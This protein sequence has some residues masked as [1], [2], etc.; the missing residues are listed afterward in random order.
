MDKKSNTQDAPL[1]II[2]DE[3]DDIQVVNEGSAAKSGSGVQSSYKIQNIPAYAFQHHL[4]ATWSGRARLYAG[5][6]TEG[7]A[8]VGVDWDAGPVTHRGAF[9]EHNNPVAEKDRNRLEEIEHDGAIVRAYYGAKA[10]QDEDHS[11]SRLDSYIKVGIIPPGT[12]ISTV[13]VDSGT[14][15]GIDRLSSFRRDETFIKGFP[16][17]ETVEIKRSEVSDDLFQQAR[18]YSVW[19]ADN[20]SVLPDI[21]DVYRKFR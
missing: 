3:T 15:D 10:N 11:H 1:T 20:S 8:F 9:A 17:F 16:V 21:R 14:S 13:P 6:G 7:E 18:G 12:S 4:S 19:D 2:V 5:T